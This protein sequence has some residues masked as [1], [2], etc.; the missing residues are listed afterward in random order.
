M[1]NKIKCSNCGGSYFG[2]AVAMES[3]TVMPLLKCIDC[4]Y[5]F[6]AD[7]YKSDEPRTIPIPKVEQPKSEANDA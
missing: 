4:K 2:V 1:L 5:E 3:L 6:S 7:I